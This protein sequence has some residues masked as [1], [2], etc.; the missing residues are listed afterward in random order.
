MTE[1]K[2]GRP[3]VCWRCQTRRAQC[4][5]LRPPRRRAGR[6]RP[7]RHKPRPCPPW[8]MLWAFAKPQLEHARGRETIARLGRP[9]RPRHRPVG[10]QKPLR[11]S[12]GVCPPTGPNGCGRSS[13]PRCRA[14]VHRRRRPHCRRP[15]NWPGHR[16]N[17]PWRGAWPPPPRWVCRCPRSGAKRWRFLP[18]CRCRV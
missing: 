3:W 15:A 14:P 17:R 11:C 9:P 4:P 6:C 2:R 18:A 12:H 16:P 7:P 8:A 13:P 10:C 5:A 1:S